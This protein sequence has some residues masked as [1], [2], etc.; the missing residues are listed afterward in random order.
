MKKISLLL[1]SAA[2]TLSLGAQTVSIP[3]TF[4]ENFWDMGQNGNNDVLAPWVTYGVSDPV[5]EPFNGKGWFDSPDKHY[6]LLQYGA[7][8]C[9]ISP[10]TFTTGATADEWLITPEIEI[11]SDNMTLGV[12]SC[13]YL[14]PRDNRAVTAPWEVYISESGS[15]EK[16]AFDT[17][18]P[19]FSMT[20]AS[21]KDEV[22]LADYVFSVNG[23]K[24][25]KVRFAF[26]QRAKNVGN[27]GFTNIL[28]GD[29]YCEFENLTPY[30]AK[31]GESVTF[32]MNAYI[33][34]P[35]SCR[36][37]RTELLIDGKSV[38]VNDVSKFFGPTNNGKVQPLRITFPD[39]YVIDK[40]IEYEI[41]VTPD[42]EGAP[43]ASYSGVVGMP[44][45]SYLNNTV[46][47]EVTATGCSFC[48]VGMA[49]MDYMADNYKG[50]AIEGKFI[51]IAIHGYMNRPDPMNIP[52]SSYLQLLQSQAIGHTAYPGATF[53]R[54]VAGAYPYNIDHARR[55]IVEGSN[56]KVTITKVTSP[57]FTE[58]ED[59][60]GKN[61]TVDFKAFNSFQANSLN[62]S[63]AVVVIENDV[64]G[65]NSSY[66]QS[67]AFNRRNSSYISQNYN[68]LIVP[69]AQKYC[70]GGELALEEIP[71]DRMTYNHVARGIFPEYY[72]ESIT[73]SWVADQG[74]DVSIT[75]EIP[76]N[77]L[78]WSN[79]EVIVL[80]MD[81]STG[82]IVGSDIV[83]Y[84]F[85]TLDNSGV[86]GVAAEGVN[87]VRNGNNIEVQATPGS[88]INIF[89]V[90]GSLL[91]SVKADDNC[92][93]V[94]ASAFSGMVIVTVNGKAAKLVF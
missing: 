16:S 73:G 38:A 32:D 74:R 89:S 78:E 22:A 17:E 82:H 63:A 79:S 58:I 67:N 19:L 5:E 93:V 64:V 46:V 29:F 43:T 3:V 21:T 47:E 62:L 57:D 90:D 24:G 30:V 61:V 71:F 56:N 76:D 4:Q 54:A 15:A 12:T 51:G 34:A 14:Y 23:Y 60:V 7:T 10:S 8:M 53:N 84:S 66:N 33:K 39:A 6:M 50:S 65:F 41:R 9:A 85:Y 45:V 83:P 72:G 42:Y 18:N 94:D 81:K 75:F 92:S 2:V 25:K 36:T 55:Q 37:L 31:E 68:S 86:E 77:I 87:V 27:F 28:L 1:A 91:K 20:S 59:L 88:V 13:F 80:L 44:E 11:P 52:S 49:S 26:V 48:P 70:A 69:Y 35:V 40:T